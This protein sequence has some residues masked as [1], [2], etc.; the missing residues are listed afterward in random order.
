M[1]HASVPCVHD[2]G[3][4]PRGW[5]RRARVTTGVAP[6]RGG[7]P[8]GGDDAQFEPKA[9]GD[10]MRPRRVTTA[11]RGALEA[12]PS[13]PF[14]GSPRDCAPALGDTSAH[15]AAG[16]HACLQGHP[17]QQRADV[18][19]PQVGHAHLKTHRAPRNCRE[20]TGFAV[21]RDPRASP[22]TSRQGASSK[23]FYIYRQNIFFASIDLKWQR[24]LL[25]TGSRCAPQKSLEY[26]KAPVAELRS[27]R[28]RCFKNS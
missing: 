28:A 9:N 14:L 2:D 8:T 6:R 27:A 3:P 19:T 11:A 16:V 10:A 4:V 26:N 18:L 15:E 13:T 17:G 24:L 7:A 1:V 22:D 12:P 21:Q 23:T 5:A 20:C 25:C